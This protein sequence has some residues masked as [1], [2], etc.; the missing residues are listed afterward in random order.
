MHILMPVDAD[1]ERAVAA[2]ETVA[3]QPCAAEEI[4]VTV[5]NVHEDIE[6]SSVDSGT[7]S[8]E[9]WF[10]EKDFP[11]SV[12]RA[13]AVLE[14]AGITVEKHRKVAEPGPGIVDAADELGAD[15]VVM[16]GRK[17]TPVGKVLLGSVAQSVLL[18][19]SVPVT[20]T[21]VGKQ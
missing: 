20:V 13:T 8:S 12:G 11:E 10:D 16:C 19:A 7:V 17:R 1:E 3:A 15:Q 18:N 4:R 9:E 6:V 5:L 21:D 2:A 14:R